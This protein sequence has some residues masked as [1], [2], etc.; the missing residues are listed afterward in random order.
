V[1]FHAAWARV[2]GACTDREDV[3][4]GT[5]LSGRLQARPAPTRMLGLF[6]NT[7][8]DPRC[9]R[10]RPVRRLVAQHAAALARAVV[11]RA[12]LALARAAR[13]SGV[14]R[15]RAAVHPLH[16]LRHT[17]L[18]AGAHARPPWD[19]VRCCAARSARAIPLTATVNDLG[20]DFEIVVQSAPGI[21]RE[22]VA[23]YLATTLARWPCAR[24]RPMRAP[25]RAIRLP[26]RPS[27]PAPGRLQRPRARRRTPDRASCTSLFEQR[28]RRG[29]PR[30]IDLCSTTRGR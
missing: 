19:G 9:G 29:E 24:E 21:A 10:R 16:E 2:L 28:G 7:L 27:A 22:R 3:V 1:L 6:I 15:P 12:G 20:E 11:A 25:R 23:G 30:P 4:F 18:L 13:C 26:R 14:A 5:T 17:R 8:P